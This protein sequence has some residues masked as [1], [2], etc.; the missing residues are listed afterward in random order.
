MSMSLR[1]GLILAIVAPTVMLLIVG[2]AVRICRLV[3]VDERAGQG[4]QT[5]RGNHVQ[6]AGAS[7]RTNQSPPRQGG[8][9]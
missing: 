2:A 9:G 8:P 3:F 7:A 1:V 6:V 4:A 5:S